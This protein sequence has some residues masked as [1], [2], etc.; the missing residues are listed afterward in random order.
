M[1][2]EALQ[3][4]QSIFNTVWKLF[5]GWEIPGT[6]TTPAAFILYLGF[7][8]II[9]RFVGRATLTYNPHQDKPIAKNEK[10]SK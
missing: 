2:I 5:T 6:H 4:L 9:L 7:V 8:G 1:T 3:V 10:G